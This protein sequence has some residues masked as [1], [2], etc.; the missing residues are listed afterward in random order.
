M[1]LLKVYNDQESE[2]SETNNKRSDAN[3]QKSGDKTVL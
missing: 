3:M 1:S 2:Q